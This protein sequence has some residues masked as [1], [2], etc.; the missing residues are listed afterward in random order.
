MEKKDLFG[1]GFAMKLDDGR[2]Q[3]ASC[4]GV[5]FTIFTL[6]LMMIYLYL[7]ADV[8]IN[9]K[10]VNILSTVNRLFFRDDEEFSF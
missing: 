4:T 9:K 2:S 8:L 6:A 1:T 3:L 5:A 7:K 10:D